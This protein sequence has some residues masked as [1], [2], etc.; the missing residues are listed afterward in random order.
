MGR[1]FRT[2]PR[3]R[4]LAGEGRLSAGIAGYHALP[5]LEWG[6]PFSKHILGACG[7]FLWLGGGGGGNSG[8]LGL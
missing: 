3:R 2:K 1:Q 8:S 5:L 6:S 7:E 4:P